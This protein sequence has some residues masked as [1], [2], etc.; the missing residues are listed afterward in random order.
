MREGWGQLGD[1][2]GLDSEMID[3]SQKPVYRILDS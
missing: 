3:R 1:R 2:P